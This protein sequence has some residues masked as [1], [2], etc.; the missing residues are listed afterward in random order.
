MADGQIASVGFPV[1]LDYL[2]VADTALTFVDIGGDFA[3]AMVDNLTST[4]VDVSGRN[5]VR[6]TVV[7]IIAREI[8]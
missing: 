1:T 2:A 6:K 4:L 3:V 7:T 8:I 5:S